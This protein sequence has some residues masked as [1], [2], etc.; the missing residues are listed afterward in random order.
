VAQLEDDVM[1]DFLRRVDDD[2]EIGVHASTAIRKLLEKGPVPKPDAIV[3]LIEA[4]SEE[5][6]K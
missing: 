5:S 6:L 1:R 2:D 3:D 4:A